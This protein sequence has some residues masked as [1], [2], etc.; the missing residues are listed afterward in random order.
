L[1]WNPL[2]AQTF[3]IA[4]VNLTRAEFESDTK[5]VVGKHTVWNVLE[6]LMERNINVSNITWWQA[7]WDAA[8]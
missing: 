2:G 1:L 4:V 3:G 5:A 8:G 6:C 7:I